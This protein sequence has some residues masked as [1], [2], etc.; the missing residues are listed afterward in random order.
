[1]RLTRTTTKLALCTLLAPACGDDSHGLSVSTAA[2]TMTESTPSTGATG[3]EP[4]TTGPNSTT[5]TPATDTPATTTGDTS[6]ATTGIDPVTGQPT[7]SARTSR[8]LAP[9]IAGKA[10]IGAK[11]CT[12]EGLAVAKVP[13]RDKPA[14]ARARR[15]SWGYTVIEK[16]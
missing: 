3:S 11:L 10:E 8:V 14:Y 16:S 13:R 6:P 1:M 2:Q 5:D 9:P 4:T 12:P 7:L 15:W